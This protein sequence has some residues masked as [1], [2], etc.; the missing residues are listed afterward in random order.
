MKVSRIYEKVKK[1]LRFD[2]KKCKETSKLK[3]ENLFLLKNSFIRSKIDR[4][5]NYS[6]NIGLTEI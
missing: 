2:V 4:V 3:A 5:V 1:N 6:E